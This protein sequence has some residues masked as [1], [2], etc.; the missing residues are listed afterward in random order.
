MG[1][2]LDSLLGRQKPADQPMDMQQTDAQP[3]NVQPTTPT[4]NNLVDRSGAKIIPELLI[5]NVEYHCDSDMKRMELWVRF[6]NT[7]KVEVEI[8]RIELLGQSTD[9]NRIL[10]AGESRD[11]RVYKG[12]T[13]TNDAYHKARVEY[14]II[15]NGDYFEAEYQIM[16]HYQDTPQGKHFLPKELRLQRPIRD[17]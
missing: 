14:K 6:R 9:P 8:T 15:E 2:I 3:H 13:P 17:R 10:S 1:W 4:D 5:D 16:Y 12:E 11:E 7:A